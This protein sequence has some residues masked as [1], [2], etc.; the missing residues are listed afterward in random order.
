MR[1]NKNDFFDFD[2]DTNIFEK[3]EKDK[4]SL[5]EPLNNTNKLLTKKRKNIN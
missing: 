3:L 1:E 4:N 2:M 5:K